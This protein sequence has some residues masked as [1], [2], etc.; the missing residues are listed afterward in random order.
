MS[1]PLEGNPPA[2]YQWYFKKALEDGSY[3][4]SMPIQPDRFSNITL[5]NNDQTLFFGSSKKSIMEIIHVMQKTFWE[6][7]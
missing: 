4:D 5:L 2:S 6:T 7:R 1:C 3:S